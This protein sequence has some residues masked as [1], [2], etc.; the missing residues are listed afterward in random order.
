MERG[1]DGPGRG[2]PKPREIICPV[3]LVARRESILFETGKHEYSKQQNKKE[4]D[5]KTGRTHYAADIGRTLLGALALV[6]FVVFATPQ[7]AQAVTAANTTIVNV[8]KVDYKDASGTSSFTKSATASITINLLAAAPTVGAP[9][10][11]SGQ[12]VDSGATQTYTLQLYANANGTDTYDLLLADGTTA[13]SDTVSSDKY[14]DSITA[15]DGTLTPLGTGNTTQNNLSI[16]ATVIL[17]DNNGNVV[18]IPAG[19]LNGIAAADFVII[20]G[21]KYKVA[22]TTAGTAAAHDDVNHDIDAEINGTITL[23]VDTEGDEAWDDAADFSAVDLAGLVISELYEV[24]ITVTAVADAL[25]ATDANL[26]FNLT[27][28]ADSGATPSDSQVDIRTIFSRSDVTI[29]KTANPVSGQPGDIIEYTVTVVVAGAAATEVTVTDAV[30]AYTTLVSYA[31]NYDTAETTGSLDTN[32]AQIADGTT[33][34]VTISSAV[35]NETA[36]NVGS[37][38]AA[39]YTEGSVINFY[40]GSGSDGSTGGTVAAGTTYTI[41]Y[42]VQINP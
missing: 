27:L 9:S 22:G 7:A 18:N 3:R 10:P 19:T 32:F 36:S 21:T 6:A 31:G 35:D 26:Y 1:R 4:H 5:M 16:G 34:D 41:K 17:S 2:S 20:G 28:T 14:I 37:G 39:N 24:D 42:K 15:P 40:L 25:A 38:S 23:N 12:T 13:D 11:A 8:V 30:P 29:T 33:T